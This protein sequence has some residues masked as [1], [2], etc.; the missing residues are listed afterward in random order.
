MHGWSVI[1]AM[2]TSNASLKTI[3]K[4]QLRKQIRGLSRDIP[5]SQKFSDS[6]EIY[7]KFFSLP[8][9]KNVRVI[10]TYIASFPWEP[11][12]IP[13]IQY[14]LG[15][16]FEV[17][18][19]VACPKDKELMHFRIEK[20]GTLHRGC[21]SV[22]EPQLQSREKADPSS[23][24]LVIVPGM[25]FDSCRNR[26]GFGRGYYDKFLPEIPCPKIAFAYDFQLFPEIPAEDFDHKMDVIIT[27]KEIIR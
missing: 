22:W 24:D 27:E 1:M 16:N 7:I 23:A 9:L 17:I 12:T 11:P 21:Y 8:E 13:L 4:S 3:E 5:L 25:A 14:F 18:I 20:L 15:H 6:R 2:M 26:L 19:P 10:H